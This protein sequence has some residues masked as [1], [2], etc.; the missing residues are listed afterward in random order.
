VSDEGVS[1]LHA[2]DHTLPKREQIKKKN[3]SISIYKLR[4]PIWCS[5]R[6]KHNNKNHSVTELWFR[7]QRVGGVK[8]EYSGLWWPVAVT[9][10]VHKSSKKRWADFCFFLLFFTLSCMQSGA[11]VLFFKLISYQ[12]W[13]PLVVVLFC[14]PTLSLARCSDIL[15]FW[16]LLWPIP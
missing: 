14:R 10:S 5:S 4:E 3:P 8:A 13:A 7:T 16:L 12:L 2:G 6:S 11:N 9:I 15:L 1:C